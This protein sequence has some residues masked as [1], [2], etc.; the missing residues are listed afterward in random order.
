MRFT[1][2]AVLP[3]ILPLALA[4]CSTSGSNPSTAS[5]PLAADGPY[6]D[7]A[8]TTVEMRRLADRYPGQ[9]QAVSIGRS[10]EGREIRAL[11][12]SATSGD[13]DR[14]PNIYIVAG[15]H[16]AEW[17][18]VEV[19]LGFAR[20]LLQGSGSG[21]TPGEVQQAL[22]QARFYIVPTLNPDGQ[23]HYCYQDR[24]W[25]KTRRDNGDGTFG[26]NLN[27]NFPLGWECTGAYSASPSAISSSERYRG[28]E[29]FSEPESQAIRDFM[30]SHPPAG[31]IDYHRRGAIIYPSLP[32]VV[33]ER[34]VELWHAVQPEMARRMSA[35]SG[36]VYAIPESTRTFRVGETPDPSDC[37]ML[38]QLM[39]WAR[40]RFETSASLI[41]LPPG[42]S[43][44]DL[45]L[46][47]SE[48]DGI[49]AEQVPA[50]LYFAAYAARSTATPAL[51]SA[52]SDRR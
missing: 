2:T 15:M 30:L 26:V 16:A 46:T 9:A 8:S 37:A 21:A 43:D 34:D 52:R 6:H 25:Y 32:R 49:V 39:N 28:T 18:G 45:A 24:G 50:I 20:Y 13:L 42:L 3:L 22:Q 5:T 14:K 36:R 17:I 38:G 47:P 31:L 29:P 4:S 10:W 1:R 23:N 11:S 35:V 27:N 41:E 51:A 40:D 12:I 48:V 44:S 33:S 7:S 19:A